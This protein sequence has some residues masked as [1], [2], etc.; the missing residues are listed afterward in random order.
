MQILSYRWAINGKTKYRKAD[1][2][3]LL[4]HFSQSHIGTQGKSRG[5]KTNVCM[6]RRQ[7][8]CLYLCREGEEMGCSHQLL[9]VFSVCSFTMDVL[10]SN[11]PSDDPEKSKPPSSWTKV[12]FAQAAVFGRSTPC[13]GHI[14]VETQH[15]SE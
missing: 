10:P 7:P 13:L 8:S 5:K 12:P 1:Y 14:S 3:N 6:C 4:L 9:S 2:H 15:L 11:L